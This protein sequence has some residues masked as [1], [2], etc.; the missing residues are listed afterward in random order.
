MA[1]HLAANDDMME[2]R[3]SDYR[4]IIR[5]LQFPL[6]AA[7]PAEAAEQLHPVSSSM[8]ESD[9]LIWMVSLPFE[10]DS[11]FKYP[12][13]VCSEVAFITATN[14]YKISI[15]ESIFHTETSWK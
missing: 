8:F 1:S 14:L 4:E 13:E 6:H 2:K 5:R 12:R 3:N 15:T 10:P 11:L 9:I 7:T